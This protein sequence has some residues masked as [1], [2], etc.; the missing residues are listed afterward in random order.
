LGGKMEEPIP[1]VN[2]VEDS[3]NQTISEEELQTRIK[4]LEYRK[5]VIYDPGFLKYSLCSFIFG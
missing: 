2:P 3:E 4:D 5:G 1:G